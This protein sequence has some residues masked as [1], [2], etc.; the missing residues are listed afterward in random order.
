MKLNQA[1]FDVGQL[2]ADMADGYS[3]HSAAMTIVARLDAETL[4]RVTWN[5]PVGSAPCK[6]RTEWLFNLR[7]FL[8]LASMKPAITEELPR[9]WLASSLLRVGD[10]LKRNDYF[11][12]APERELVHHLRNGIAHGNRFNILNPDE[13][14]KF[15]AHNRDVRPKRPTSTMIFEITPALHGQRVL[16]DFLKPGDVIELLAYVSVYLKRMGN[17][18]SPRPPKTRPLARRWLFR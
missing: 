5:D 7:D 18:E 1:A 15:P 8:R 2:A 11:D 16:F 9:V 3:A 4:H 17:G 13:L 6:D 12:R 14:K 10:A